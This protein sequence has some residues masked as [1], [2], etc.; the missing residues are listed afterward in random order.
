M[1][2]G[3]RAL[4]PLLFFIAQRD[5]G[6]QPWIGWRPRSGHEVKVRAGHNPVLLGVRWGQSNKN[7][8]TNS[9]KK[10]GW[11]IC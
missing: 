4:G 10:Y 9:T 3:M 2:L 1:N 5:G 8:F 7:I 11:K 6:P